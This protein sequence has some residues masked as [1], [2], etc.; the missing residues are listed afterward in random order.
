MVLNP[1]FTQ[2]TSSE[3]NLVQDL[4]NEQLKMYGVDIFYMPRKYLTENSVIREVIQSKFDMALPLEAY[5]DNYD[6][7]SGAGNILSKFGIE[8]KDEVRLI[9]SR[10]RFETYITPLIEDQSNVKLSTRPKSGD[11]IW[12]PLDDRVYEI[13]DIEYAKPYYQLQN[14]YVYELYCELF[15]LEDEVIATGVDEIDNNLIGENYDGSTDDGI[16]TIQG[17]TQTL[18][19]VGAAVTSTALTSIVNGAIRFIRVTNRGGGYATPPRVAISSAPSGGVTGIATA[20][21]IGGINVCNLNANPKLQSVQQVQ[22]LNA[23][24]GYVSNPGVRFISNTGTGA[25]GIV[26]ISTT[27]GVGIVTVN[28]A[29]SGYVT[30]PTVTFTPPKHVGAAATAILDAPIVSTGVSVTSAPIS[31]GASSFLFPGGTT[32]GVFYS[33]APTV[34]FALPTGTGNAAVITSTLSDISQTG[35]TVE[36]L[37]ISS[38]GKFYTSAPLVV[39]AHPG[40]SYAAAT[41]GLSG[42]SINPSSVA[43]STT[44]RAYTSAPTVT[45]GTGIGTNTPIQVAVGIA[46]INSITG[47]VTAVSFNVSDPWAVGTGATIGLGYTVTPTISFSA[48]SPVQATATVTVSAA[49]TVNSVSIGNSGF[50]YISAPVVAVAGPGGADE[51]FR[52]LGVATIRS[53][54]IKTQ[55]TI[56]IGSTSITGITTTNIIVGDRVRLGVGYSDLYNFIPADTFVTTIESNT[57]FMNNA[58]TNVGIAT[59]VFEFGRQ[60]CGVVTGIAVTFG[61]GGYLSPP[62]VTITNEVSEKNYINFPGISTATGIS[63]ISPGGTVSSVNILD[64]GYGYVIVPEVTL[65]NPESNG[66]GT[67]IFNEIITGSSSGTT[68]RVRTWDGSTNTLIVGTVAGEFARGETLVGST[69]GA[70]YELR[71]VDVQPADDG[72]A[73]NINIETE[74]DNIIDF[75]EQNPFGMP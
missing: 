60:N 12:F 68:A 67:F 26:G 54:S 42:T 7:Y 24:S 70:S 31:I 3:Q 58:T 34:T 20:V 44:G 13:K 72:F 66:S 10:E 55:G 71:I 38:G 37:S 49:G 52:A 33:T 73:D 2:G 29:G 27:G 63:T 5:V 14:L 59:S 35:G 8:S 75:S 36:S 4:I 9:I 17:P 25:A 62:T 39:V 47:I 53:T 65:S 43:F 40:T 21:M 15:R 50:G 18:T 23:G 41:I 57:I 56:G 16:N 61:G 11:L 30:A 69:S 22:L 28:A 48:P 51:Q 45:I 64:S 6:E 74:A 1:F 19:L 32:G 46:T